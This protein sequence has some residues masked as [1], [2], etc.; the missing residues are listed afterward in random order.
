MKVTKQKLLQELTNNMAIRYSVE[1][2]NKNAKA[3]KAFGEILDELTEIIRQ[4]LINGDEVLLS[5]LC[6][7]RT[8]TTSKARKYN[9]LIEEYVN[10]PE[11]KRIQ[12]LISKKLAKVIKEEYKMKK[13]IKV[14]TKEKCIQC[15]MTKKLM[16]RLGVDYTEINID[17][18]KEALDYLKEK[19]VKS[20]PYIETENE[21]WTGFQPDK[22]K[23]IME[24]EQ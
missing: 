24:V 16:N 12:V 23:Q 14:Y 22:I 19:G 11:S 1:M 5:S 13:K 2:K 7:F 4:H 9:P 6:T 10:Y 18:D 21:S 20:A 3:N 15:K 17:E 8:V